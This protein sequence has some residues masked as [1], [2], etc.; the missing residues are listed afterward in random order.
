MLLDS[1][2][3]QSRSQAAA[4]VGSS[5]SGVAAILGRQGDIGSAI[6]SMRGDAGSME[7]IADELGGMG[8]SMFDSGTKVTDQALETL[9]TGLGFIHMDSSSSPLVA[10]ALKLY[11]NFDPNQYVA[12]A[13]Q[14]VQKAQDNQRG[15]TERGLARMGVSP[16]SGAAMSAR[17]QLDKYYAAARAA[18]MT[19]ARQAGLKDQAS[20]FQS[21]IANNANTFLNTG[22]Q[23]ASIGTSMRS[24]GASALGNA[25]NLL[26]DAG[27]LQ[28]AAGSLSLNFG[29]AL[30]DAYNALAGT[31]L[32]QAKNTNDT[33]AVRVSAVNGRGAR[34][35]SA[36]SMN[37]GRHIGVGGELLETGNDAVDAQ[38]Q[39]ARDAQPT[40]Y[41]KNLGLA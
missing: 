23:L 11:G 12:T 32:N 25:G 4:A 6:S 36:V 29:N 5:R 18:A 34:G 16:S 35:G 2:I 1:A 15:Q 24:A 3:E 7:G 17:S 39:M 40:T 30:A 20:A 33:E 8:H 19:R 22:G 27:R 26:G 14:D 37:T 10:E 13:A 21:L 41:E 9:G 28:G 31:Q 38:L